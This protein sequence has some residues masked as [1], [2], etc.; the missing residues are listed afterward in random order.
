MA[1]AERRT[2]VVPPPVRAGRF[3]A[4]FV[5][6]VADTI[7]LANLGD[8]GSLGGEGLTRAPLLLRREAS[9]GFIE[10]PEP[11]LVAH[12]TPGP[13]GTEIRA[14]IFDYG[15]VSIRITLP[16][17]G[18]W[19]A[20]AAFTR[21]LRTDDELPELAQRTLDGV[22][23]EI[24]HALD[25]PHEALVED[26]FVFEVES[27]AEPITARELVEE[28]DDALASLVL[29]E[30][31]RV[32]PGERAEALRIAFSYFDDD[33][34]IVQWDTAFVYDRRDG[35]KNT[36]D[37]LE[38]ANTQ[39]V[40]LRTYDARLD[41]ELDEIYKYDAKRPT[42]RF[43]RKQAQ[44]AA[45]RLR[46]L[47]VD[48]AELTDRASNALKIIG[49]AYYAR[50]YRGAAGRLGLKDWQKQIDSKVETVNEMYRFFTDQ[51]QAAR[52]EFLE[53]VVIVMIAF[54]TI[55]GLFALRH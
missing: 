9:S 55:V 25:D 11:P 22:L 54:E 17:D 41:A 40:E 20:F 46:Y 18:S 29:C 45:D 5:Y 43:G 19:L 32:T 4:Y 28:Y 50:L 53:V 38:F 42:R 12:L 1:L 47:I 35:A 7:D 49:D 23:R 14:K 2:P 51:A 31:R 21:R 34:S 36:L 10:F 30:E 27:F 3:H 16:F 39:L 52:S 6:D 37:I 33:L 15:V 44:D 13:T 8:V 24:R 48:I 26:Y